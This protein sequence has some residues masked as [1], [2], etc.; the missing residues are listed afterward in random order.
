[1]PDK[2]THILV[3]EDEDAHAE[4]IR[5]AFEGRD[6][7]VVLTVVRDLGEARA[8][9]KESTPDLVIADL[10]APDGRGID[11]VPPGRE[12]AAFSVA[13][14]ASPGDERATVEAMKARGLDYVVKSEAALADIP[15]TAGQAMRER[16][17]INERKDAEQAL[18]ATEAKYRTL[19]DNL[20]Q[21]IFLKDRHSV[22][23]SCNENY[24]RDLNIDPDEI[25]GKT[26]YDFYPQQLAEKY[27]ADDERIMAAGVM[28]DID[29][30]YVQDGREAVVHTV[31]TPVRDEDGNVAGVL[32][33]FWD[34]TEQKRAEEEVRQLAKFPAENP[35]P[36]M[37]ISHDGTVLHANDASAPLLR[38]FE[39]RVG[40]QLSG[41]WHDQIADISG[42]GTN[43]TMELHCGERTFSLVCVPVAGADYVNLYGRDIT[44]QERLEAQMQQVAKL[45]S[46]GRLAGGVAHDFNNILTGIGGYAEL[47]ADQM[48]GDSPARRDLDEIRRL[49]DRAADLIRQLLAFSRRQHIEP[50]ALNMNA[51]VKSTT[52]MLRRII[53]EDIDLRLALAG[54]L[55]N[56]C[57][58]LSQVEQILVN[59]T[60]NAR[61]AMPQ[62]GKLTIETASVTL[63]DEYARTRAGVTPGPYG[64]L[65]V[66]DTG[67]GMDENTQKH[68]FEPFFTTRE[69]G[70]GT[71][72][73]LATVYGIVKQHGGNI[74]VYSEPARGTTFKVY[75][76]CAEEEVGPHRGRE[77]QETPPGGAETVL[78]LEDEQAVRNLAERVLK[79]KGYTVL[80]AASAAEAD[81]LMETMGNDVALLLTDVVLPG[82]N[83]REF[84]E[85]QATRHP[86]LRVLYM[87]GYADNAAAHQ[88]VLGPGAELLQKPFTPVALARKVREVLDRGRPG[89]GH[90]R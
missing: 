30:T 17:L 50:I 49:T 62:G 74:W 12:E 44:E 68:I 36:V 60:I 54:D 27:R 43:R 59:L 48:E 89:E 66:S 5:R 28:E 4:L 23:V 11:L 22:Y 41:R 77:A 81:P 61:H 7:R 78:V 1:M 31:K 3:V 13:L 72:L 35:N 69:A 70:Q 71:G 18:H 37:R 32:G 8:Y 65:A 40:E 20:P 14:M 38:L 57:A 6:A 34:I 53:G 26:D 58:D 84:Y 39:A 80:T 88:G 25:A 19:V 33:V 9:L 29:E 46:I 83:G 15:R 82:P 24:A 64:M 79:Q 42:S 10:A 55:V 67:C 45:E 87:S 2:S 52:K 63:D 85:S 90:L 76:P 47:L 86:S 56:V 21:K 51:V 73:G 75:L 16:K